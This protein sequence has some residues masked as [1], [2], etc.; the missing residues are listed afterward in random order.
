[1][2]QY[3]YGQNELLVEAATAPGTGRTVARNSRAWSRP[4]LIAGTPKPRDI[5]PGSIL[6]SDYSRSSSTTLLES[7]IRLLY[8]A[9]RSTNYPAL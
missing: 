2:L 9:F 4:S 5:R 8:I 7:P 6:R 1:M 3:A